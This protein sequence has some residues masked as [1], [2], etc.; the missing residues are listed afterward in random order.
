MS[1]DAPA[2]RPIVLNGHPIGP[3]YADWREETRIPLFDLLT[4]VQLRSPASG[5]TTCWYLDP[6]NTL[7]APHIEA[8]PDTTLQTLLERAG[9][10]FAPLLATTLGGTLPDTP[11]PSLGFTNEATSVQ[12]ACAWTARHL[13]SLSILPASRAETEGTLSGPTGIALDDRRVRAVMDSRL[14]PGTLVVASPFSSAPTRSQLSF[15]IQGLLIHRFFDA[16]NDAAFYLI[17]PANALTTKP[18]FFCP[19]ANLIVSDLPQSAL[20]PGRIL[21]WFGLTPDHTDRIRTAI[22]FQPQDFGLGSAST[23]A[24]ESALPAEP[25]EKPPASQDAS[26]PEAAQKPAMTQSWSVLMAKDTTAATQP[27]PPQPAPA[28]AARGLFGRL[29]SAFGKDRQN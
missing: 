21:A 19:K 18:A 12:L 26:A 8:L 13:P 4:C 17:W 20:L 16:E 1:L 27:A 23:L 14:G 6:E 24:S 15:E 2:T 5:T 22:P 29:R 7:L 3:L 11:A 10:V 28:P 25:A 9:T